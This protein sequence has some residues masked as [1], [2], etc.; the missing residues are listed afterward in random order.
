MDLLK[1]RKRA[2]AERKE[3]EA[4]AKATATATEQEP[5]EPATSPVEAPKPE[6]SAALAPSPRA[7]KEASTR[8]APVERAEAFR[9]LAQKPAGE[10]SAPEPAPTDPLEDFLARYDK[11]EARARAGIEAEAAGDEAKRFLAFELEGEEYAVSIM[12]VREIL[13]VVALTEV[14]RAPK[15]VLGILSKR[16]VVM[17]VIDL[18]AMLRLREPDRRLR[19]SQRILVVG[20][21]DRICGLRIDRMREVLRLSMDDVEDV[22]PSL[23]ARSTHLLRGLGRAGG[24]MLILLDVPAVLESL[25]EAAGIEAQKEVS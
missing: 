20:E 4:R 24:R 2:E 25:A 6:A 18:G 10:V 14:P 12:D 7:P 17:P 21:G 13:R 9:V 5:P 1:I 19:P 16:G 11:G 23:G 15:E 8:E 22:P 3:R